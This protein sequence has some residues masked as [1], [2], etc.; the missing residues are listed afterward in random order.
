MGNPKEAP[1]S[2]GD[3]GRLIV[4]GGLY[5]EIHRTRKLGRA[6]SGKS[7]PEKEENV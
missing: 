4:R 5:H 7:I 1:T 3:V 2:L 6:D